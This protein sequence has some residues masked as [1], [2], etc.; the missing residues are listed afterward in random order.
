[1]NVPVHIVSSDNS[2]DAFRIIR[3]RDDR[4]L[5]GGRRFDTVESARDYLDQAN[6]RGGEHRWVEERKR[7]ADAHRSQLQLP[8]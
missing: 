4:P 3:V 8:F 5:F 2:T 7:K 1:M 6:A